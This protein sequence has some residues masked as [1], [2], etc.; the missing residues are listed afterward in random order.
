MSLIANRVMLRR[1]CHDLPSSP[2]TGDAHLT[3][4]A[5]A[6]SGLWTGVHAGLSER[7]QTLDELYT[8]TPELVDAAGE[9]PLIGH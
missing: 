5:L 1:R 7:L 6:T 9:A 4:A 8:L 3:V 2:A